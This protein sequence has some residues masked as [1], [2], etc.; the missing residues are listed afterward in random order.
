MMAV[1]ERLEHQQHGT[2][3]RAMGKFSEKSLRAAQRKPRAPKGAGGDAGATVRV[4]TIFCRRQ[5]VN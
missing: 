1:G 2:T 5:P 3:R 4:V